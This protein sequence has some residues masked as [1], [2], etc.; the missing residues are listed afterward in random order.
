M[1]AV[2]HVHILGFNAQFRIF[3]H[4]VGVG[5]AG[6]F[7]DLA[8]ARQLVKPLAVPALALLDSC[9]LYTSDAADD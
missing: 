5:D 2:I 1:G 9:L 7:L 6:E 3:G 4:V 8:L